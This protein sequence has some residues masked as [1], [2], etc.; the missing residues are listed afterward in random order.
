MSYVQTWHFHK[1]CHFITCLWPGETE[2]TVVELQA[3]A[4]PVAAVQECVSTFVSVTPL[5]LLKQVYEQFPAMFVATKPCILRQ[6][7][8]VP[9]PLPNVFCE[10]NEKLKP[11]ICGLQKCTLPKMYSGKTSYSNIKVHEIWL[12]VLKAFQD[13]VCEVWKTNT[14]NLS[15]RCVK[16]SSFAWKE[17]NLSE[18]WDPF[19]RGVGQLWWFLSGCSVL[20][21][22][23]LHLIS[24]HHGDDDVSVIY[25]GKSSWLRLLLVCHHAV[26][27]LS[28]HLLLQPDACHRRAPLNWAWSQYNNL[29]CQWVA[30]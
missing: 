4:L 5:D 18:D 26:W 22:H 25:A 16:T 6:N 28:I 9:Y 15:D 23:L 17:R 13:V 11:Y 7:M 19:T 14:W 27:Q 20:P 1:T 8:I 29:L 12:I 3:R 10:R 24:K 2:G 21:L 30:W